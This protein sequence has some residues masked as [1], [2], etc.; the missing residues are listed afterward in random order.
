MRH[1]AAPAREL[2]QRDALLRFFADERRDVAHLHLERSRLDDRHV[3]LHDADDRTPLAAQQ[4]LTVALDP[5]VTPNAVGV[6]D[7]QRRDHRITDSDPAR[8]VA[9]AF[10]A[11]DPPDADHARAHADDRTRRRHACGGDSAVE[12]YPRPHEVERELLAAQ[13]GRTVRD[14]Q[15]G[16]PAW[17]P[18]DGGQESL[19]LPLGRAVV[20]LGGVEVGIASLERERVDAL[21]QFVHLV[22]AHAGAAHSRIDLDVEG[23]VAAR[24]PLEHAAPVAERR[25]QLMTLVL[26]EPLRACGHEDENRPRDAGRTQL[27]TLFDRR[28]AVAP[29]IELLEG[30]T[31]QGGSDPYALA[32]TTGRSRVPAIFATVRALSTRASTSTS[33]QAS[34]LV[35]TLTGAGMIPGP[36]AKCKAIQ[37]L[38]VLWDSCANCGNVARGTARRA[39]KRSVPIWS[40]KRSSSITRSKPTIPKRCA[41]SW[42][43]CCCISRFRSSS[44]KSA[45]SST[46]K[47]SRGRWKKR[48]GAGIRISSATGAS[49]PVIMQ[50]GSSSSGVSPAA[51]G[52]AAHWR[53]CRPT[54][55]HCSWPTGCRSEPPASDSIGRM[56][57]VRW[58]R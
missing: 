19:Q 10:A 39:R 23:A 8:V 18:A 58:R 24:G 9:D 48:C 41:T 28:H 50:G 54:F 36:E 12:E 26:V 1:L 3:H 37:R 31:Y 52:S 6:A 13:G 42:A 16:R 47:S 15:H 32:L 27:D 55:L 45:R 35:D 14:M 53:D 51:A 43:T 4:H 17:Q 40:K 38:D 2:F 11:A 57:T 30:L 46:P 29:G 20:A 34:P 49:V 25:R 21:A 22:P 56:R 44:A 5:R 7:A 33:T